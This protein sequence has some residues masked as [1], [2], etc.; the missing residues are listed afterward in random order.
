MYIIDSIKSQDD[1]I[2]HAV[3][4]EYERITSANGPIVNFSFARSR[5]H[6]AAAR[7]IKLFFSPAA[8]SRADPYGTGTLSTGSLTVIQVHSLAD[9]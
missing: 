2:K 7:Y 4:A 3:F 1:K 8:T 5:D 9:S 6:A